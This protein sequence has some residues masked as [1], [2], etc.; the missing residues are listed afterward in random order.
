MKILTIHKGLSLIEILCVVMISTILMGMLL[1]SFNLVRQQALRN[2]CLNNLRQMSTAAFTYTIDNDGYYPLAYKTERTN[3]IRRYIAW[4][5]TTWKDWNAA[6]PIEHVEPG[7]LWMGQ[8]IAKIQQCPAFSG[9]AN[10]LIDPYTGYNYNTSYI[11][12]NETIEPVN[13]SRTIDVQLPAQTVLFGDGEYVGGANKFMR[14]PFSNPRDMSFSDA[15]RYA[16][17]QGFRHLHTTNISF[18]DGHVNFQKEIF[19]CTDPIGQDILEK[20][21]QT[22]DSQTG[23][24]SSDNRLYDLK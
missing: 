4:D 22:H 14:A 6:E 19:T 20:Y 15:D 5:F 16:G 17:T 18:C 3:G 10:W 2:V 1:P 11:G 8:T 13:S 7:L 9:P 12:L 21:N 24:L 23:F